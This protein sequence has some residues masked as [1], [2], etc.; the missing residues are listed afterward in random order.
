MLETTDLIAL[1]RGLAV[2]TDHP[3][4]TIANGKLLML[5][6]RPQAYPAEVHTG[7]VTIIVLSGAFTLPQPHPG[8]SPFSSMKMTP[9]VAGI[10]V[11]GS[12]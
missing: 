6:L 5:N 1:G 12:I 4:Y 11:A 3:L 10:A 8:P 2:D 9:A 7:T